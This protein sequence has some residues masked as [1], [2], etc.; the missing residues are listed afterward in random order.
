MTFVFYGDTIQYA[1]EMANI[2]RKAS[3]QITTLTFKTGLLMDTY[4]KTLHR[5]DQSAAGGEPAAIIVDPD[6]RQLTL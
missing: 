2:K 1:T 5:D 3:S 6:Q 4:F